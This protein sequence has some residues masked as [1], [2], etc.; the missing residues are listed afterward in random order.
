MVPISDSDRIDGPDAWDRRKLYFFSLENMI[1]IKVCLTGRFVNNVQSNNLKFIKT[2]LQLL[3]SLLSPVVDS[4]YQ[5]ERLHAILV[6]KQ[7]ALF[8]SVSDRTQSCD[9][10]VSTLSSTNECR[11]GVTK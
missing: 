10:L 11:E 4:L 6:I 8:S 1:N 3:R 7:S 9:Y 2:G 5:S